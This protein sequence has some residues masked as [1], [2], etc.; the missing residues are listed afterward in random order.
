MSSKSSLINLISSFLK[1]LLTMFSFAIVMMGKIA[2]C[3]FYLRRISSFNTTFFYSIEAVSLA[4]YSSINFNLVSIGNYFCI[5]KFNKSYLRPFE[6]PSLV[7]FTDFNLKL[8]SNHPELI[9]EVLLLIFVH[10]LFLQIF[11]P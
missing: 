4:S 7:F 2:S 11:L 1:L 8:F 9:F 3:T 10:V 5:F 6:L